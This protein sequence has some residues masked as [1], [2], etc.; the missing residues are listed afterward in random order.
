[1]NATS[2]K[3]GH[4]VDSTRLNLQLDRLL[5]GQQRVELALEEVHLALERLHG[6]HPPLGVAPGIRQ[7]PTKHVRSND[8]TPELEKVASLHASRLGIE[9]G[10]GVR[11]KSRFS[12]D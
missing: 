8:A 2:W 1:M 4:D 6:T 11:R 10:G 9:L 7:A 12:E 3:H 5:K